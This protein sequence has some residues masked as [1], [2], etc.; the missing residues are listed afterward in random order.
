MVN[1]CG[2]SS[3]LHSLMQQPCQFIIIRNFERLCAVLCYFRLCN[4]IDLAQQVRSK[5]SVT[6]Q[7]MFRP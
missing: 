3:R 5:A 6:V 2:F 7:D 1:V 4:L